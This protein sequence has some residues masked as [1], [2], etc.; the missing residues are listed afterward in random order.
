MRGVRFRWA[1]GHFAHFA[2]TVQTPDG[3]TPYNGIAAQGGERAGRK[4]PAAFVLP[5][6]SPVHGLRTALR[7]HEKECAHMAAA[8]GCGP[9]GDVWTSTGTILVLFILLVIVSRTFFL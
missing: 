9:A 1:S 3:A 4:P 8:A 6:P 5:P 2:G 7:F